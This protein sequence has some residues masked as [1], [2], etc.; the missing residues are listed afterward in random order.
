MKL[1][2]N[3]IGIAITVIGAVL[4]WVF[5]GELYFTANEAAYL[6]GRGEL[7]VLDPTPADIRKFKRSKRLSRMG[8]GLII[9]GGVFQIFSNYLDP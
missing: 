6:K 9:L 2:L 1:L 8:M 5:L 4:I 3:S 7:A